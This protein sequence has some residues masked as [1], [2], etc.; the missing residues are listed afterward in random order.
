MCRL[1]GAFAHGDGDI[2]QRA[3]GDL[4]AAFEGDSC[5]RKAHRAAP[6]MLGVLPGYNRHVNYTRVKI[7]GTQ[8]SV[9][10]AQGFQSYGKE[11]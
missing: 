4:L 7:D 9:R 11:V 6:F 8:L 1:A 2:G 5:L 3:F 10:A